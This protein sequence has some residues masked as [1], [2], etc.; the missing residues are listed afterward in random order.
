[1]LHRRSSTAGGKLA[2]CGF[3]ATSI[4]AGE[5]CLRIEAE[6]ARSSPRS[7]D[8]QAAEPDPVAGAPAR[9]RRSSIAAGGHPRCD[10]AK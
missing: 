5:A 6:G 3:G 1:M 7:R 4:V 10:K 8:L 2:V 9:Q